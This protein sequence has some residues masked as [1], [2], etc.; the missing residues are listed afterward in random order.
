MSHLS[1]PLCCFRQIVYLDL[2][3]ETF[4]TMLLVLLKAK[5]LFQ[6]RVFFSLLLLDYHSLESVSTPYVQCQAEIEPCRQNH[7]LYH[8]SCLRPRLNEYITCVLN[9]AIS[10]IW[11]WYL[12]IFIL[13]I[14]FIHVQQT[15][16]VVEIK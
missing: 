13:I 11:S 15:S 1:K 5:L 4:E 8:H 6:T 16:L 10:I 3:C 12:S 14:Y 9:N 7:V 2:E